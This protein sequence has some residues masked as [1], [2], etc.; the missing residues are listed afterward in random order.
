MEVPLAEIG[1]LEPTYLQ[2]HEVAQRWR[3]SAR[4]LERWRWQKSGPTYTK[5][6]GRVVYAI[7]DIQAYERR[8]RAEMH[9]SIVGKWG[10]R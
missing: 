1:A 3:V 2:Q 9:P 6:G 7:E 10:G 5:I 4:T 8:R